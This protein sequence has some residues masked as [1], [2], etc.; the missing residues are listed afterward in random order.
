MKLLC[1]DSKTEG[2]YL[3]Y[4]RQ[5]G[6]L[7]QTFTTSSVFCLDHIHRLYIHETGSPW[8][9][10]ENTLENSVLKKKDDS[11]RQSGNG[12]AFRKRDFQKDS[13]YGEP[14][15]RNDE[16]PVSADAVCYLFNLFKGCPYPAEQCRYPHVCG[17]TVGGTKCRKNHPAY[18]H[19]DTG[20]VAPRFR[21]GD[22]KSSA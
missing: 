19:N 16:K 2:E 13:R 6:I 17:V 10:I 8:N 20:S 4:L 11:S 7:L 3:E 5:I 22:G 1:L 12:G 14:H 15:K 21:S 18:M 9:V